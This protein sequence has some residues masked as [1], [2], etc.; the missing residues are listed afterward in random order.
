MLAKELDLSGADL[1]LIELDRFLSLL[2]FDNLYFQ[3]QQGLLEEAYWNSARR[4]VKRWVTEDP[5]TRAIFPTL[6]QRV[7]PI[8]VEVISELE[9]EA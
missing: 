1:K 3:F 9:D 7:H 2:Q 6:G 4:T 8:V 5:F